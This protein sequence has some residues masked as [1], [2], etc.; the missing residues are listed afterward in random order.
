[1]KCVLLSPFLKTQRGNS[2]TVSRLEK[3]LITNGIE[4]KAYGFCESPKSNCDFGADIIHGF[5]AYYFGR[6]ILPLLSP[7]VPV[8]LTM[9]GTDYNVDLYDINRRK[10]VLDAMRRANR[11][12]VFHCQAKNQINQEVPGIGDKVSIISPGIDITNTAPND[13]MIGAGL[14]PMI[15]IVAGLRKVKNVFFSI[16]AVYEIQKHVPVKLVHI[17]PALEIDV[18][19]A[20][21]KAAVN[22]PWFFTLGEIPHP[23]MAGIYRRAAVVINASLSEAIPNSIL[24]AMYLE[25]PVIVSEIAGNLS[26]VHHNKTGLVYTSKEELISNLI[27]LLD[28]HQ[29]ASRLGHAAGVFVRKKF[30]MTKE[31]ANYIRLYRQLAGCEEDRDN[32]CPS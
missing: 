11:I 28:D 23:L 20:I 19:N 8:V 17:G 29:L 32:T 26:V 1:M 14:E 6:D 16:K 7:D 22:Y 2:I 3:A 5:H 12:T 21:Q 25:R 18:A 27:T 13:N 31:V 9:T 24:E 4:A 15:L 30:D 10:I